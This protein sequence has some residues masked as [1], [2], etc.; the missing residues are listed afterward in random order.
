M[1]KS[2]KKR[3]SHDKNLNDLS[4]KI[5]SLNMFCIFSGNA[6]SSNRR[7]KLKWAQKGTGRIFEEARPIWPTNTARRV[8]RCSKRGVCELN[9]NTKCNTFMEYQWKTVII[10]IRQHISSHKKVCIDII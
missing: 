2:A 3:T 9:F 6:F 5:E 8:G 10:L 1:T 4:K 7:H